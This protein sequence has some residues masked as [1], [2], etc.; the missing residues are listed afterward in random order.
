GP[1]PL[2]IQAGEERAAGY[3]RI[4]GTPSLFFNGQPIQVQNM[5]G[6]ITNAA[7]GYGELRQI[8]DQLLTQSSDLNIKLE[9]SAADGVMSISAA[10]EGVE[11]FPETWRLRLAL[12]ED[13]IFYDAQNGVRLHEMVV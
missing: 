8:I 11:E 9:A 5:Y 10:V 7:L 1:D 6:S 12:A 4:Q 2:T 13:E 3:Y